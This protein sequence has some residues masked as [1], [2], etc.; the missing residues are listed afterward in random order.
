[1]NATQMQQMF[2]MGIQDALNAVAKGES[3]QTPNVNAIYYKNYAKK[4][5]EVESILKSKIMWWVFNLCN[6]THIKSSKFL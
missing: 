6:K 1:M 5:E 4:A 3:T 2:Q